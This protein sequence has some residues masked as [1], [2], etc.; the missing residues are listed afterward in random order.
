M[1]TAG[2]YQVNL[3]MGN[4]YSGTA[5]PGQRVF[6]VSLEGVTPSNL[7]NVDLSKQ[8]GNLVGAEISDTVQVTDGILNIQFIHGVE[9]PLI[10]GIFKSSKRRFGSG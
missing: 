9:N 2:L 7:T 4:G 6:S 10:N 1:P 8:F 5:L 3:F